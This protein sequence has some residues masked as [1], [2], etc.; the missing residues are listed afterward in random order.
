MTGTDIYTAALAFLAEGP[1][2]D[3]D[4]KLYSLPWLNILLAECLA[5]ENSIRQAGGEK[6]LPS[7]PML[8]SLTEEIPYSEPIVR[9]ALP[10]GLASF[11]YLDDGNDYRAEDFRARYVSALNEAQKYLDGAVED[12]YGEEEE[13][14]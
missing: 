5:V 2:V 6:A 9:T 3:P 8:E 7:A 1:D 12:L 10:Y 14:A 13:N 4:L 11:F